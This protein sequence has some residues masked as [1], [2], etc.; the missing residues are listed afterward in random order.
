MPADRKTVVLLGGAG[1]VGRRLATR[2]AVLPQWQ[3]RVAD[4]TGSDWHSDVTIPATLIE[5]LRGAD[6][7]INLAAVH[8]DNVRPTSRYYEVNVDGAAHICQA[9]RD[10]GISRQIFVS[11]VAVYGDTEGELATESRPHAP[12][13]DYGKSKSEAESVYRQWGRED[14]QRT[15]VIVRP[16]VIFGENNRG[17]LYNLM[18]SIARKNFKMVGDGH[19]VKSIAYVENVAQFLVHLMEQPHSNE[20]VYNY[21]DKPDL[22]TLQ[23]VQTVRE[24]LGLAEQ[25]LPTAPYWLAY[26]C[27]LLLDGIR[28]MV[29]V[30]TEISAQRVRKFCTATPIDAARAFASG[31]CAPIPV[32][33]GLRQTVRSEFPR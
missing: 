32:S 5:P 30:P 1:F 33:Q 11:S 9:C 3:V 23:I 17:N 2:L 16:T 24:E 10:L 6:W 12:F 15:L 13:N 20:A 31:Y 25:R 4:L 28:K 8:H 27:G 21:A 19:V 7:V 22:T 14:A 18:Q 26:A 29:P